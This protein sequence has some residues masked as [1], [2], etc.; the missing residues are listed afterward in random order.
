MRFCTKCGKQLEE[1]LKFCTNCG[2]PVKPIDNSQENPQASQQGRPQSS[3]QMRPQ[4]DSRG[5]RSGMPPVM[6]PQ[7]DDSNKK[8]IVIMA[9]ILAVVV[10][11]CI[12]IVALF[13]TKNNDNETANSNNVAQTEEVTETYEPDTYYEETTYEE[14]ETEAPTRIVKK[15]KRLSSSNDYNVAPTYSVS[16]D[17]Y[18]ENEYGL[19]QEDALIATILAINEYYARAGCKFKTPQL[20]RYFNNQKWYKNKGK[21]AEDKYLSGTA[22]KNAQLFDSDRSY[23]KDELGVKG[24]AENYSYKDFV[25]IA[26]KVG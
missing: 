6:P 13:L 2:E 18:F 1:G 8:M 10:I 3:Q 16:E 5:G 12:I 22:Y 24:L 9:A 15:K 21:V 7:K 4:M 20:Q 11:T 19:N 17:F 23:Y 25:R 14:P 26:K